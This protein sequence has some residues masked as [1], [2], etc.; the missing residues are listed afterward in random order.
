MKKILIAGLVFCSIAGP[1]RADINVGL[2]GPFTGETAKGGEQI[3]HGAEQ[4]VEDINAAGG[5][6][7]EK[8][9]LHK[10]DDAC[11]PKQAVAAADK[12]ASAG[13]KF[14]V[15]HYCSG[16]AIPAS[17]V[18]MD[19]NV[20]MITPA[21][22]NPKLTDEAKGLI[23]RVYGRDD[24]QGPVVG[25]Y[26]LKHF[27]DKKIA[28]V[29]DQSAYGLGIAT[30]VK[31]A[32][33]AQGLKEIMFEAIAPAERDYSTLIAKLKRAHAQVLFIGGYDTE[34][35]LIARQMKEQDARIQIIGGDGMTS[36]QFWTIAGPAGEGALMSFGPD[37][38]NRPQAKTAID[39]LRRAGYEPEGVTLYSYAAMQ[40]LA[41]G[42]RRAG[43]PDPVKVAAALRQAPVETI[44][45][46][47]TFDAKGDIGGAGFVIYRWHDGKYT[48]AGD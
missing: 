20:L 37:P 36:G 12:L 16:A 31:K 11:D 43:K 42:L 23:F 38:R 48:E 14:V 13:I 29:Q 41:E 28:I 46:P 18:Y 6:N 1:A 44:I 3:Q 22:S 17:K 9:I 33:N 35:G 8:I 32:L 30:E 10:A 2:V 21:S 4:A 5:I 24:K 40:A 26:L 27:A 39:E 45:G 19:E 34:A 25:E 47:L 15:G 7:G